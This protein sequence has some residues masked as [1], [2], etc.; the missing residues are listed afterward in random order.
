MYV[1]LYIFFVV[2][3]VGH[4]IYMRKIKLILYSYIH[5][6]MYAYAAGEGHIGISSDSRDRLVS[7][8]GDA[9]RDDASPQTQPHLSNAQVRLTYGCYYCIPY[10]VV[11]TCIHV[12]FYNTW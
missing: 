10:I 1:L 2:L 5:T 6:Y 3:F 8:S 9:I 12:L 4:M 11:R 7:R